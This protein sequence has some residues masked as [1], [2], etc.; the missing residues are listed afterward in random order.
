MTRAAPPDTRGA[1]MLVPPKSSTC[2]GLPLKS[3]QALNR[4][5]GLHSAQP[6][7]PGADRSGTR[8]RALTPAEDSVAV[9]SEAQPPARVPAPPVPI[10]AW[11]PEG[12]G[13]A[14]PITFGATD[15]P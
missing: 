6:P 2:A 4:A 13:A 12:G 11:A 7:W 8:P 5:S 14:T 10:C 3:T 9:L 15:G 1:D